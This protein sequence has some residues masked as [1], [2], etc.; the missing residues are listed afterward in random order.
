MYYRFSDELMTKILKQRLL[1]NDSSIYGYILDGFPKNYSQ[2][3]SLFNKEEKKIDFPNSIILFEDMEDDACINRLKNSEE[4]LKD[5]KDPK[6]NIILER[7]NRRL[8]KI[9][10]DKSK[11]DYKSLKDFFDE[12]ENNKIFKDKLMIIDGKDKTVLDII[13]MTQEFIKKNNDNMINK[14]DEELNKI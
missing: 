12:E 2:L 10:E 1:Q 6:V 14:I 5:P 3:K 4:V 9:K 7:A 11:E 8:N 13:K